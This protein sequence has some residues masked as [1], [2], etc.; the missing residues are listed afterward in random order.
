MKQILL[1]VYLSGFFVFASGCKT[2]KTAADSSK[3]TNSKK[4]TQEEQLFNTNIFLNAVREKY[5]GN[6]DKAIGLFA[7]CLKQN[8][9]ND[10]AL[11]EMSCLLYQQKKYADA[12]VLAQSAVKKKPDNP[13]YLLLLS[14]LYISLKDYTNAEK[15]YKLLIEKNPD[16]TEYYLNLADMYISIG[17]YNEAIK[18]YN[19]FENKE[20]V[21]PEIS[22]QKEKLY[23]Q[24]GKPTKAIE[25][26]NK[27]IESFP[28]ETEYLGI[29]AD[30]YVSTNQPVQAYELYQK[31]LKINPNDGYVHLSLADYY[32]S[33]NLTEKAIDELKIAFANRNLDV[34]TKVKVLI[35][36]LD[37][38]GKKNAYYDALI[39]LSELF[40]A[41]SP[42]EAKAY[43]VYGDILYQQ[44][45]TSEARDAFRKVTQLDSSKYAI[46]QQ[47]ILIDY[48]LK[49]TPAILKES[50]KAI[51]L[52][53]EQSEP[54]LYCGIAQ[55][56]QKD[57]LAAISTL[58]AGKS[59]LES[60]DKN[61]FFFY[62]YL[63]DCYYQNK[64]F[65]LAFDNYEKALVINPN[66]DR[67]LNNYAYYLALQNTNLNRALELAAKL[68]N[69]KP[70]DSNYQDT[71]AWVLYKNNDLVNAKVW[72]EKAL[73][74]TG[75]KNASILDHYGD[76]LFKTNDTVK[77]V[78]YWIKAKEN[79]MSTDL[80]NKK[81]VEKKLYE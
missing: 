14:E 47:I 2:T 69:L 29:L 52:F 18:V 34:D 33:Q 45:K 77:A 39:P 20:G 60:K 50:K 1:L 58:N 63:G 32:R 53:P 55:M 79:G 68:V 42:E 24:L 22:E 36:I 5:L 40:I 54:Y 67:T 16:Q 59:F 3:S 73:A 9:D 46:W 11:Y 81:I 26:M 6:D 72:I 31:I 71:Y 8:P 70:D 38:P 19:D 41:C 75:S 76:I 61:L 4:L 57:Y 25:E 80:L 65:D 12:A 21:Q 15:T 23:M 44:D 74:G 66:D 10:G 48:D 43:S 35:T 62:S 28:G 27:L 49:D 37:T 13:W 30:I 7:Q 64:N 17:K 56:N 78:E 51:E